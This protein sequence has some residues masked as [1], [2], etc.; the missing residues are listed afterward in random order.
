MTDYYPFTVYFGNSFNG[1]RVDFKAVDTANAGGA[2][3]GFYASM[4][5]Y[6]Y[7]RPIKLGTNTDCA[8]DTTCDFEIEDLTV[9]T[10][11]YG[12]GIMFTNPIATSDC[13]SQQQD[14]AC[15]D[16]WFV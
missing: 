16:G 2:V 11:I 13:Q 9:A 15:A 3:D 6:T 7:S 5:A 8:T 12:M 10:S 4:N 1:M 14:I